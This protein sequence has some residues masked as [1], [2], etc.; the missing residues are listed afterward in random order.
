M[1]QQIATFFREASAIVSAAEQTLR[2]SPYELVG[3]AGLE[4]ATLSL[5]G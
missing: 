3:A 5:E 4:P 2:I 1:N